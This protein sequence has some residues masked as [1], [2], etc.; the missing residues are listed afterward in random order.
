VRESA[1]A[2][3]QSALSF[4]P[5]SEIRIPQSL[6]AYVAERPEDDDK[7]QDGRDAAA[8]ELPRRGSRQDGAQRPLHVVVS[9]I[10]V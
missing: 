10:V 7:D 3:P 4:N 9:P 5:Q 6:A 1:L 2:I 8:A